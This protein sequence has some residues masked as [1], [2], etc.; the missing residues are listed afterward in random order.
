[1][2]KALFCLVLEAQETLADLVPLLAPAQILRDGRGDTPEPD[3]D[4]DPHIGKKPGGDEGENEEA[5]SG[6]EQPVAEEGSG[7][8]ETQPRL[9]LLDLLLQPTRLPVPVLDGL[10]VFGDLCQKGGGREGLQG[11]ESPQG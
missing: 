2:V 1:E 8:N 3:K 6:E 9:L 5:P 10:S 7:G 11:V 4:P